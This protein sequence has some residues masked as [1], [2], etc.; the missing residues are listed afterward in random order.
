M[1]NDSEFF[2]L[3]LSAGPPPVGGAPGDQPIWPMPRAGSTDRF[4]SFL[5]LTFKRVLLSGNSY[6]ELLILD[7]DKNKD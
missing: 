3:F 1:K 2:F 4:C 7:L 5:P 6:C